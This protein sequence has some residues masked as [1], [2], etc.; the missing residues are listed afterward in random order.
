M[1]PVLCALLRQN[2]K[3]LLCI[4]TL[5][6]LSVWGKW[7]GPMKEKRKTGDGLRNVLANVIK[8]ITHVL[9]TEDLGAEVNTNRGETHTPSPHKDT[10]LLTCPPGSSTAAARPAGAR[11]AGRELPQEGLACGPAH[12]GGEDRLHKPW[13]FPVPEGEETARTG[14]GQVPSGLRAA[15]LWARR[16]VGGWPGNR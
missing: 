4:R 3:C 8:A 13:R 7:G 12:P 5:S 14:R 2:E 16:H 6:E 11:S 10:V 9:S 15:G 1:P